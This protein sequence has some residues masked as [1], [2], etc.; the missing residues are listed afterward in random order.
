[1]S[2]CG[3]RGVGEGQP[4]RWQEFEQGYHDAIL[5]DTRAVRGLVFRE[6]LR[7]VGDPNGGPQAFAAICA[8][9][10]QARLRGG[11]AITAARH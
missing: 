8:Q 7:G 3:T 6:L 10:T 9:R 4:G 1:V 5:P 2:P 11:A